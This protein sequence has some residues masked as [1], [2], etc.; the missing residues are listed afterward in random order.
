MKKIIKLLKAGA[1][2]FGKA[3]DVYGEA[4]IKTLQK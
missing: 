1:H 3:M 2:S 4:R